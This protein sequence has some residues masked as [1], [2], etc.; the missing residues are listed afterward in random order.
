MTEKNNKTVEESCRPAYSV[1]YPT[2]DFALLI[3][4][5]EKIVHN[6]KIII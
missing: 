5:L 1:I 6:F 3:S 2:I 4:S